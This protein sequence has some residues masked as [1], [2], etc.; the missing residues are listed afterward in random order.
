[1]NSK[2]IKNFTEAAAVEVGTCVSLEGKSFV[3]VT[4]DGVNMRFQHTMTVVQALEMANA[5]L[6]AA[7]ALEKGC[8]S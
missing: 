1:M 3:V 4:S 7:L 2:S 6:D 8:A 5:L